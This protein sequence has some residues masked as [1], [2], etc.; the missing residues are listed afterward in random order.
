MSEVIDFEDLFEIVLPSGIDSRIKE[1]DAA[2][3]VLYQT[4][5]NNQYISRE[6]D[7][8]T[9]WRDRTLNLSWASKT[10]ATGILNELDEW[11]ARYQV[12][13]KRAEDKNQSVDPIVWRDEIDNA[14]GKNNL[15]KSPVILVLG[16]V[17]ITVGL[18]YIVHKLNRK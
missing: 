1:L 10:W 11:K 6:Y 9:I 18:A 14:L 3:D 15:L 2:W 13:Y 8:W 16:T 4:N 5:S 17:A 7:L 12:A